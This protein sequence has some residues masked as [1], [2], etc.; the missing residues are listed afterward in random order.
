[1][2]VNIKKQVV[3]ILL[4]LFSNVLAASDF[5]VDGLYYKII[6]QTEVEV[7]HEDNIF[8]EY[9]QDIIVIPNFVEHD[10]VRYQVVRVGSQ[11]FEGKNPDGIFWE[12]CRV[13]EIVISEGIKSIGA[14]AFNHCHLLNSVL[15]PNSLRTIED[16]AFSGCKSLSY[17]SLPNGIEKFGEGVFQGCGFKSLESVNNLR[18]IG[19]HIAAHT[20]ASCQQF[21]SIQI[22]E[23]VDSIGEGAFAYIPYLQ[24]LYIPKNVKYIGAY[25]FGEDGGHYV[26]Y[27][28]PYNYHYG[29]PLTVV[30]DNENLEIGYQAFGVGGYDGPRS[31]H[32]Q[33]PYTL[34]FLGKEPPAGNGHICHSEFIQ[35]PLVYV[36]TG[37]GEEYLKSKVI[38]DFSCVN[39]FDPA[40]IENDGC[41]L[42]VYLP[43]D[44]GKVI[45]NEEEIS[46]T[47]AISIKSGTSITVQFVPEVGYVLSKAL[48]NNNYLEISRENVVEGNFVT[49]LTTHSRLDC[50]FEPS[51]TAISTIRTHGGRNDVYSTSQIR[52][53]QGHHL[54]TLP[55]KGIYIQDGRKLVVK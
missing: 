17:I 29:N 23:W 16:W 31:N 22:P 6:S 1:M 40:I 25:A 47:Q 39:E 24:Y 35:P 34:F 55:R 45:I 30:F 50:L 13:K 11:A 19:P 21:N 28:N 43:T 49:E 44:G 18:V 38:S 51:A 26:S 3:L 52:D 27:D 2:Q 46:H 5:K 14:Y 53:L 42:S 12:G 41:L 32:H 54:K 9:D 33:A 4:I 7:S 10:G 36:P 15:L 48:W 20:F 37:H 8:E